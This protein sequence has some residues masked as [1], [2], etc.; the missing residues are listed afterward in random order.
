M[1]STLPD[2]R[3]QAVHLEALGAKVPPDSQ[4]MPDAL[5]HQA[6][7]SRRARQHDGLPNWVSWS[8]ENSGK[9]GPV[10]GKANIWP[11]VTHA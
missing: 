2:L 7:R 6:H 10:L 3:E 4:R 1:I 9:D 8:R 5:M 11:H